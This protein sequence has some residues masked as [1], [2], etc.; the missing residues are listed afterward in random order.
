MTDG[1]IS[2][3]TLK[4]VTDIDDNLDAKMQLNEIEC[5]G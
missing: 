3:E 4:L 1:T 5:A 2:L